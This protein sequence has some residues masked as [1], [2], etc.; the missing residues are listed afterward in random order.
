MRKTEG[1]TKLGNAREKR[2]VKIQER[3]R[4]EMREREE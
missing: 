1:K 3:K 2:D 4:G